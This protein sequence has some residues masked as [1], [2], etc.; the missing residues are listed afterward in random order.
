MAKLGLSARDFVNLA[1]DQ[2]FKLLADRIAAITDPTLRAATAL[3]VFGRGGTAMLPM[4]SLGTRGI[5]ALQ[6]RARS[7]GLEMSTDSAESGHAFS[8]ALETLWLVLGKSAKT[9]GAALTPMLHGLATWIT[10]VVVQ[11]NK[12]IKAHPELIRYLFQMGAVIAATGAAIFVL[13]T[14]IK[15]VGLALAGLLSIG[16]AIGPVFTMVANILTGLFSPLGLLIGAVAA[17][18]AYLIHTSRQSGKVLAWLGRQFGGLVSDA[19]TAFTA[20]STALAAGRVDLAA[21]V[22][23]NTLKLEWA[24][25]TAALTNIWIAFQNGFGDILASMGAIAREIGSRIV[26]TMIE[27]GIAA[28]QGLVRGVINGVKAVA[29]ATEMQHQREQIEENAQN[30]HKSADLSGQ[31]E[32]PMS[33]EWVAGQHKLVEEQKQR[34]LA[35]INKAEREMMGG[36]VDEKGLLGGVGSRLS[37]I[38]SQPLPSLDTKKFQESLQGIGLTPEQQ[39]KVAEAQANVVAAQKQ[40]AESIKAA[41][42]ATKPPAGQDDL[43]SLIE[44][45]KGQMTDMG[46]LLDSTAKTSVAGTFNASSAW[47]LAAGNDPA[48]QTAKNTERTAAAVEQMSGYIRTGRAGTCFT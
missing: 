34:D 35:A 8:K 26:A 10:N 33:A 42:G 44:K 18:A 1:P 14:T 9:I 15:Y 23:W 30:A 38:W 40:W 19:T 17:F 28:G 24:K 46:D 25:G 36:L 43:D 29:Y 48:R 7:L 31:G 22:F 13:G 45:Y 12:W 32:R 39:K 47:G 3:K 2:Q 6:E 16:K 21:Q 20:I 4:L 27:A 11:V 37:D 41:A 5:D